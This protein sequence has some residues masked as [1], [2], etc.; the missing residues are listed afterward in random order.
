MKPSVY[1]ETTIVSYLTAWPSGNLERAGHQETTREWWESESAKYQLVISDL[2]LR[3]AAG[4]DSQAPSDRLKVLEKISVLETT[5]KAVTL[6]NALLSAGALPE[7]A[8]A[9]ALHLSI[10]AVENVEFLL[11]W[12]CRHLANARQRPVIESVF[13][14]HNMESPIICTPEELVGG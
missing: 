12:N 8:L 6:S 2:V 5:R 11:T 13:A 3:E 10:A 14:E 1:I 9:D 4:G 7:K